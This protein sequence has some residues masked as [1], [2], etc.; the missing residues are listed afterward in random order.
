MALNLLLLAA[1][2]PARQ[3][4]QA[5]AQAQGEILLFL[6]DDVYANLHFSA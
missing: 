6:D 1:I 4:N 2:V 5:A 3:R